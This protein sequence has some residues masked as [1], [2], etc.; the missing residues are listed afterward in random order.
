MDVDGANRLELHRKMFEKKRM[1]REVFTEF[2]H[3]FRRLDRQYFSGNGIEVELGSGVSPMR[4]SYPEVLATDVV[5]APNLDRVINAEAMG[6]PDKSVR[7]I[8]GQN[9]FHHFPRPDQFF[10]E[11]DRVL[12]PGGGAILLEPYYGPFA[13]F[14][15]KRLFRTEGFDKTYPSW[16]TPATGPMNGANQALSYIVFIR[17]RDR[18]EQKHPSLEITHQELAGNY[19]KYLLSGGLNFRQ[20]LPDSFTG[21]IGLLENIISPLNRWLALHH[22]IVIRKVAI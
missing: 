15:Y 12:A 7:V 4:D 21:I 8:Y 1:L 11:L 14:L 10:H 2:H 9:C 22:I 20:L 5:P 19:L 16:E 17:D 6:F 3:L 18:F 13:T